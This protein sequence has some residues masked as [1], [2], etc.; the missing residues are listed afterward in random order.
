MAEYKTVGQG[1]VFRNRNRT[2]TNQP[3]YSGDL[4][5]ND[6]ELSISM[7]AKK[8]KNGNTFYSLNVQESTETESDDT[9]D[10]PEESTSEQLELEVDLN[11]E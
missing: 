11:D 1:L 3:N 7:W 8:D 4:S 2:N 5:I 9:V 6:T 10:S